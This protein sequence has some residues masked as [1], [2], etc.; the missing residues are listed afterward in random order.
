MFHRQEIG[1]VPTPPSSLPRP[2]R[3]P[4][5]EQQA[6]QL[7]SRLVSESKSPGPRVPPIAQLRL[8]VRPAGPNH[9]SVSPPRPCPGSGLLRPA[10]RHLAFKP[11][12]RRL[13][14]ASPSRHSLQ[15]AVWARRP[16]PTNL[17]RLSEPMPIAAIRPEPHLP[18]PALVSCRKVSAPRPSRPSRPL[19][20]FSTLTTGTYRSLPL[21][22]QRP[23]CAGQSTVLVRARVRVRACSAR[24]RIR[25][26]SDSLGR[27]VRGTWQSHPRCSQ[28]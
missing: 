13:Y 17:P 11:F 15:T 8:S 28:T 19:A 14:S 3:R 7:S 9:L 25:G 16:P 6:K 4:R 5:P 20:S 22:H 2:P 21:V 27:I 24:P 1:G 23:A 26:S 12:G 10:A 18:V